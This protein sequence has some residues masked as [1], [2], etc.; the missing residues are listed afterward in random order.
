VTEVTLVYPNGE[1]QKV[2][3]SG[4]P[5]KGDSIRLA[6]GVQD[7]SLMVEHVLWQEGRSDPP[8]PIVLLIVRPASDVPR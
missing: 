3:L 4:V 8:D 1:R 2:L 5:R 6:N 7:P